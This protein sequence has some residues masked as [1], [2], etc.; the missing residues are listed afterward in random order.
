MGVVVQMQSMLLV[1][2]QVLG[3]GS[4]EDGENVWDMIV[5]LVQV[6]M[7]WMTG[8]NVAMVVV[9]SMLM[10]VLKDQ[11]YRWNAM[12][13][14]EAAQPAT[15]EFGKMLM[16]SQTTNIQV[17]P[18]S[19]QALAVEEEHVGVREGVG[20]ELKVQVAAVLLSGVLD[21]N[22]DEES[23]LGKNMSHQPYCC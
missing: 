8:A 17:V 6:R 19:R 15:E 11:T 10:S 14:V 20:M 23:D 4:M 13:V 5:V 2:R 7:H 12:L 18:M 22:P 3:S 9:W 1:D 21:K 16:Q